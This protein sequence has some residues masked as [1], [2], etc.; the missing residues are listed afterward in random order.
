VTTEAVL[1]AQLK[2]L[3]ADV[4]E[5]KGALGKLTEAI[6]KLA[7]IEDRQIR[8]TEALERAFGSITKLS[9]RVAAVEQLLPTLSNQT[10]CILHGL[11]VQYGGLFLAQLFICL[12]LQVFYEQNF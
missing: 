3:H 8:S 5:I 6:T 12:R 10:I 7:L 2:T 1:A 9:D 11:I 4:S